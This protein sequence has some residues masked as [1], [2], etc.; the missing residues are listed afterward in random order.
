MPTG[1]IFI[2]VLSVLVL[3]HEFGH[4]AA[5]KLFGIKVEEFAF[6][7]PF[8][9][10]IFKFKAKKGDQTQYSVYPLLF[11]GFVK[12]HGEEE[13]G[14]DKDRSFWNRGKKQRLLVVGAGIIMNFI[15]AL[16]AFIVLY[17]VV[18]VPARTT[19]KIT[20]AQV[21]KNS[22]AEAAGIKPFDRIVAVEGKV[23][24][25]DEEFSALMKS[26]GGVGVNITL[27]R[28]ATQALFEGLIEK[29]K[30]TIVINV[31]PRSNPPPHEG[32]VG[33][34]IS[35]VPYIETLKC[36]MLSINCSF[37]AVKQGVK[38]TGVWVGRIV[39]GMRS[40]GKSLAAGKAP[41]G[42]SG[43]VG[44]YQLTGIIA[45]EGFWPLVELV[46]VLSVNLGVFNILPI[47][48]LD[49]GRIFFIVLEGIRGKKISVEA[50]Q[51]INSWGMIFLLGLMALISLQDV[52]RLGI[53]GKL[54][55]K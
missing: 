36:N 23:I 20:V 53:F 34:A 10:P 26:W 42:V 27:E 28:G 44:I 11:G 46:A 30:S 31:V 41:E 29:E 9:P 17:S 21:V 35:P 47:P 38:S 12:L 50:E 5:A 49:G 19:E 32:A 25:S 48:A 4:F 16:T 37:G 51:K 39:D 1:L 7:L 33:V 13:E 2:I 15:L 3:V 40:I 14:S 18:G 55:G 24:T 54:L 52:I 6:G 22:P 43:P 8:T 45:A